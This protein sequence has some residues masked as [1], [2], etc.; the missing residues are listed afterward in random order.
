LTLFVKVV[1]LREEQQFNL[2]V[3]FSQEVL[4]DQQGLE[5]LF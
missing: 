4:L 3:G 1:D 5:D 2:D